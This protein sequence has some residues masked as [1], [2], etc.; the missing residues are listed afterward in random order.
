M[1]RAIPW[2]CGLI[3]ATLL[4]A[5]LALLAGLR[6]AGTGD[7]LILKTFAGYQ[8]GVPAHFHQEL[9]TA[10]SWLLYG[11]HT[12]APALPWFSVMQ[13]VLLWLG[14]AVIVKSLTRCAVNRGLHWGWGAAAGALLLGAYALFACCRVD[15]DLTGGLLGAAAV[16]QVFSPDYTSAD[17]RQVL[18]GLLASG[19]LLLAAYCLYQEGAFAALTLWALCV[20][21]IR[22]TVYAHAEVASRGTLARRGARGLILSVW[23]CAFCF[24]IFAAVRNIELDAMGEFAVWQGARAALFQ[25]PAFPAGVSDAM[26]EAVGWSRT[27]LELVANGFVYDA[28]ITAESMQKLA[29]LLRAGADAGLGSM[30]ARLDGGVRALAQSN[31]QILLAT[32]IPLALGLLCGLAHGLRRTG[33]TWG[34][35][36]PALAFAGCG[37]WLCAFAQHGGLRFPE[38]MAALFPTAAALNGLALFTLRPEAENRGWRR[39]SCGAMGAV[40]AA[41]ALLCAA[42][43]ARDIVKLP[44]EPEASA[45]EEALDVYALSKPDKLIFYQTGLARDTRLFPDLSRV[46]RNIVLPDARN[47]FTGGFND[48]LDAFG[49]DGRALR[50]RDYLREN[51]LVAGTEIGP[52]RRLLPYVIESVP[53]TLN[54]ALYQKGDVA[55][56]YRLCRR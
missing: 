30:A 7:A 53:G 16:A 12:L 6:Y 55:S 23:I 34:W 3:T 32:A 4:L 35:L 54:W 50:P 5:A 40:C 2:L 20:L 46:P 27:R 15:H 17:D 51:V 38:A 43:N 42:G 18:R 21:T 49:I 39:L 14:C 13:L 28:G 47:M 36:A 25:S 8:G 22:L 24:L 10:L 11:L 9:H 29:G 26:L 52:W 48:Q 44:V 37:I 31:P 41:L 1:K 56:L 45:F 19:G 33:R